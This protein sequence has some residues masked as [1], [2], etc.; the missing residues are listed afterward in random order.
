MNKIKRLYKRGNGFTLIEVL[1]VIGIIAILSA[2]VLIAINPGRQFK[3]A[4]DSQRVS[5][6]NAIINAIGQN[7]SENRGILVCEGIVKKIPATSTPIKSGSDGFDLAPCIIPLYISSLP[8]DPSA[9]GAHYNSNSDYD[10][11]YDISEDSN[12][13]I[14]ASSTGEISPYIS[15]TR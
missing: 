8:Y 4:R 3:L 7:M 10:T 6:V 9:I 2:V 13:R 5:N 12:G 15:A 1:V 14:T 11:K